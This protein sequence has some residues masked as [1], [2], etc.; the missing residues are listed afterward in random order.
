[1]YRNETSNKKYIN[2]LQPQRI[3]NEFGPALRYIKKHSRVLKAEY[4]NN[5][6]VHIAVF[7]K[8]GDYTIIAE[9][10]GSGNRELKIDLSELNLKNKTFQKLHYV[11]DSDVFPKSLLPVAEPVVLN[12]NCIVEK[13]T[14]AHEMYLFT[15]LTD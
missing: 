12:N 1:M 2:R 8:D 15:T 9:A 5:F 3:C 7:E 6:D 10:A 11:I 13:L 4:C 14:T